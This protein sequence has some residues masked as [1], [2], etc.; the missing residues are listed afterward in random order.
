MSAVTLLVVW[1]V[2]TGVGLYW[3]AASLVG[4]AQS[5]L[6]RRTVAKAR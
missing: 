6:L 5:L 3:G 2:A 1:R 4:V